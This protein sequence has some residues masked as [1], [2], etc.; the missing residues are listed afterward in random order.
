MTRWCVA[1]HPCGVPFVQCRA[2][3]RPR[4]RPRSTSPWTKLRATFRS[5]RYG[6]FVCFFVCFF[7][8]GFFFDIYSAITPRA[9]SDVLSMECPCVLLADWCLPSDVLTQLT[10]SSGLQVAGDGGHPE[11]QAPE[12]TVGATPVL[13]SHRGLRTGWGQTKE[14]PHVSRTKTISRS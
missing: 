5:T 7:G 10:S 12:Q 9:P 13:P 1:W 3:A 4:S 6:N 8:L 2:G 11:A 14:S